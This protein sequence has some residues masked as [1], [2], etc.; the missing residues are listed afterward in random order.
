MKMKFTL[1]EFIKKYM[2]VD[3]EFKYVE[4]TKD[5][6]CF[7]YDDLQNLFLTLVDFSEGT[8]KF[9]IKKENIEEVE[10]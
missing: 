3:G 2:H 10:E 1:T 6:V 5:Y 7:N 9:E 8:L 4:V